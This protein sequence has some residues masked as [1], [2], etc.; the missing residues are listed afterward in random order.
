MIPALVDPAL[1]HEHAFYDSGDIDL[2]LNPQTFT[3]RNG[4]KSISEFGLGFFNYDMEL[5]HEIYDYT[6]G[7]LFRSHIYD[8]FTIYFILF[9]ILCVGWLL[10]CL[11]ELNSMRKFLTKSWHGRR[12]SKYVSSHSN[13]DVEY[14]H[15]KV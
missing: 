1:L 10:A 9:I 5:R 13:D 14:H 8:Y 6:N 11:L 12:N 15:I 2:V 7:N 4:Y 3:D